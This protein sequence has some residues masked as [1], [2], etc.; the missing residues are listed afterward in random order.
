METNEQD[1]R[2]PSAESKV[3]TTHPFVSSE[4]FNIVAAGLAIVTALVAYTLTLMLP[5][6]PFDIKLFLGLIVALVSL[7]PVRFWYRAVKK[8]AEE[9]AFTA[10]QA[11][12]R[13]DKNWGVSEK[14]VDRARH[15]LTDS[16]EAILLVSRKTKWKLVLPLSMLGIAFGL[17][18]FAWSLAGSSFAV[19]LKPFRRF[20]R[21]T[22]R[23]WG[24]D[25][26]VARNISPEVNIQYGWVF[27]ALL[28]LVVWTTFLVW[29][30][31]Y[32]TL[33]MVTNRNVFPD[34]K[35]PPIYLPTLDS[36]E[37]AW[38]LVGVKR[39]DPVDRPIQNLLGYG[40][41]MLQSDASKETGKDTSNHGAVG[42]LI[43]GLPRHREL[44][45]VVRTALDRLISPQQQML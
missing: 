10:R 14:V 32:Y 19:N 45:L 16:E 17:I 27:V 42:D 7:V 21:R 2:T 44:V 4:A 9:W 20:A 28:A 18:L 11:A 24:L 36:N 29:I 35:L 37:L 12:V 34:L 38:P 6:I 15:I 26:Q 40:G 31:W 23:D 13:I 22:L 33:F 3:Y 8:R 1:L 5:F 41:A 43:S 30:N 25:P 39:I